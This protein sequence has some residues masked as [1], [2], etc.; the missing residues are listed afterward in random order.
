MK[1]F[2]PGER[3]KKAEGQLS[4]TFKPRK[5]SGSQAYLSA[6]LALALEEEV[7][8]DGQVLEWVKIYL[9][10]ASPL[11][12]IGPTTPD[13]EG[14]NPA[15]LGGTVTEG[16]ANVPKYMRRLGALKYNSKHRVVGTED[17]VARCKIPTGKK[18]LLAKTKIRLPGAE[19]ESTLWA[20]SLAL[21]GVG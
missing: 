9:S 1:L 10:E 4:I 17:L 12:A 13:R 20:G 21:E 19:H 5:G 8:E 7:A 11:I 16:L 3:P 6:S 14:I 18:I 2:I 15:L